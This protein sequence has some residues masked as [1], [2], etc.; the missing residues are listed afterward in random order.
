M[1]KHEQIHHENSFK[2]VMALFIILFLAGAVYTVTYSQSP[3]FPPKNSGSAAPSKDMVMVGDGVIIQ[4]AEGSWKDIAKPGHT[5]TAVDCT[6]HDTCRAVDSKGS[7]H[8]FDGT[9]WTVEHTFD[10]TNRYFTDIDCV[11][12][13]CW[14]TAIYQ[15]RY[16]DS[17][18]GHIFTNVK[19]TWE[20]YTDSISDEQN[21]LNGKDGVG[22]LNAISCFDKTHC[23]AV[24]RHVVELDSDG[25]NK[26]RFH[27]PYGHFSD[28]ECYDRN[29]C[30]AV[31]SNKLFVHI[32][33][34]VLPKGSSD[35]HLAAV[36]CVD[37]VCFAGEE[38]GG[39]FR[40]VSGYWENSL[41]YR[42]V[43]SVRTMEC[44]TKDECWIINK[45]GNLYLY[46][47]DGVTLY[48]EPL[49]GRI[50][51]M[52][53]VPDKIVIPP[54]EIMGGQGTTAPQS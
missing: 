3:G 39:L 35:D 1:E 17:R 42:Y 37:G 41:H 18:E 32:D 51:D 2:A 11:D 50:Y 31:G 29:K 10:A 33:T 13:V 52:V 36:D 54:E 23:Y 30:W 26:I 27:D 4:Y 22:S 15:P 38:S 20:Q 19:G 46:K 5:F 12:D 45:S 16:Y 53:V 44:I 8:Q 28:V 48:D 7:I 43:R 49:V 6:A 14:V 9:D 34:Y 24:G 47:D 25:L 21:I 40:T